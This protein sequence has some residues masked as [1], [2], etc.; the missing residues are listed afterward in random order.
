[1]K[2]KKS[3]QEVEAE[4]NFKKAL[5]MADGFPSPKTNEDFKF[6]DKWLFN[7]LFFFS[8]HRK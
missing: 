1:M 2:I 6:L 5:N 7:D 4:R 3:P 8:F